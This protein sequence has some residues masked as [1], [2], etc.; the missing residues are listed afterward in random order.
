MKSR[1]NN[2]LRLKNEDGQTFIEFV[3]LLV[4]M[5]GI[6]YGLLGGINGNVAKRWKSLV[7]TIVKPTDTDLTLAG[8]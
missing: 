5:I 4:V 7:T 2:A 3:L 1:K 8:N 6:S